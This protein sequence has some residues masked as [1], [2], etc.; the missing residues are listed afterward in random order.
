M[1]TNT[2]LAGIAADASA[3]LYTTNDDA[4]NI[5][6]LGSRSTTLKLMIG[7]ARHPHLTKR[8]RCALRCS[9]STE[10]LVRL[11]FNKKE[12]TRQ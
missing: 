5:W 2:G 6:D 7:G 11:G 3:V 4:I 10:P 9:P 1:G 8:L 12:K